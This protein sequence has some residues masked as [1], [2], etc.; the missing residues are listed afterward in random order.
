MLRYIG[1][2]IKQLATVTALGSA[3]KLVDLAELLNPEGAPTRCDA[4]G[5]PIDMEVDGH[6]DEHA[7]WMHRACAQWGLAEHFYSLAQDG[8][9]EAE[10]LHAEVRYDVVEKQWIADVTYALFGLVETAR[11]YNTS[12]P[13]QALVDAFEQV[14]QHE[15]HA[16]MDGSRDLVEVVDY[17]C[18]HECTVCRN[19]KR[20]D[21]RCTTCNPSKVSHAP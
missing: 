2:L 21:W 5:E 9:T 12:D 7:G 4:C 6:L 11:T 17:S 19:L 1:K 13:H 18:P 8:E 3:A 14:F 10:L 16:K 20:C 15:Q